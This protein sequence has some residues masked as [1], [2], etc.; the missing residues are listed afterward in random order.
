[1]KTGILKIRI[2]LFAVT[3]TLFASPAFAGSA[4]WDLN[5][6]SGDWNTNTNWTPNTGYPNGSADTATFAL[7]NTTNVS[8]SA[9]TE[10]NSIVFNNPSSA[11]TIST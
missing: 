5:P 8:I 1:M 3:F 9:N 7:S 2:S 11:F 6:G 4:T 10:A